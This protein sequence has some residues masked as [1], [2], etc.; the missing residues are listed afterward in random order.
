[1]N[2]T[3]DSASTY[4]SLSINGYGA[5]YNFESADSRPDE[6]KNHASEVTRIYIGESVTHIGA[7]AF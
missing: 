6:I 7:H 5:M 4:E 2:D 3:G 1:M